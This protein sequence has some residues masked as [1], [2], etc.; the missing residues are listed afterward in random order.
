MSRCWLVGLSVEA[1][2]GVV[3]SRLMSSARFDLGELYRVVDRERLHHGFTWEALAV[4]V[5]VSAS[6]IR[7]YRHAS[8]AE[9]D[10]VLALIRWLEAAP[11][12]FVT[13]GMIERAKLPTAGHG[14]VRVDMDQVRAASSNVQSS[15]KG[16]RTTI[17]RLVEVSARSDRPV[18]A[19]TRLSHT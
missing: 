13:G 7:R 14:F 12:D 3:A 16:S 10:G 11:E 9:A 5:G 15:R 1:A 6:T 17:Q 4:S 8:D 2:S 18:V 19:F